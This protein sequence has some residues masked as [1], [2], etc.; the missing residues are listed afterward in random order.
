MPQIE[1][2]P[3]QIEGLEAIKRCLLTFEEAIILIREAMQELAKRQQWPPE[4]ENTCPPPD[5]AL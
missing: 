4:S 5:D 2:T 1:L 3:E